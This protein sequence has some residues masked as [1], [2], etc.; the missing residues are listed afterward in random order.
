MDVVQFEPDADPSRLTATAD[1]IS[2]NFT[3]HYLTALDIRLADRTE[4][5]RSAGQSSTSFC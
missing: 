3:H 5:G 2:G 1:T 4:P